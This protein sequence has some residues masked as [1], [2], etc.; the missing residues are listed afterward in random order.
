[1]IPFDLSLYL[2]TD[3]SLSLGRPLEDV[4][5]EAVKGGVTMVQLREKDC[6]TKDF[7][8]LAVRLKACLKQYNIPLIINDRLDIALACDAE[9]LHIGQS[10]MPYTIARKLLGKDKIIGLSVESISDAI[11]AN[12]LD[13][14]YIGISPVFSTSTKTDTAL[15][16]GLDGVRQISQISEHPSVGIGG[17]NIKN[18]KDIILAGAD[19]LS[20]VSAIMSA[21]DPK[22]SAIQLRKIIDETKNK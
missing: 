19:G 13:V 7:Y 9:G 8:D 11:D 18:A 5:E 2:V 4:V 20:V 16:F 3:R 12:K 17:I 15:A 14:D 22:E 10:D 6:S 1:M 21:T